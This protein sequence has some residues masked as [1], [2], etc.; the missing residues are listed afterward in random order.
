[1]REMNYIGG[2]TV[3]VIKSTY[4]YF[5]SLR[6]HTNEIIYNLYIKNIRII[7]RPIQACKMDSF[8]V[9]YDIGYKIFP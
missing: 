2:T 8:V 6:T 5:H 9:N 3:G 4:I 7:K 1:M